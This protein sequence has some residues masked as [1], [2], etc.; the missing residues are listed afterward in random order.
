[1]YS[2]II[3]IIFQWLYIHGHDETVP[4]AYF[5]ATPIVSRCISISVLR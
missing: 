4:R 3:G 5:I 2:S 1:M